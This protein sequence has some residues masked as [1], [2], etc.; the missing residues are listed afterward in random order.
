VLVIKE[1]LGKREAPPMVTP[2][3]TKKVKVTMGNIYENP[4]QVN[5]LESKQMEKGLVT[6][7]VPQQ[8]SAKI[9][10]SK[11]TDSENK[12][13]QQ[14]KESYSANVSNVN[15]KIPNMHSMMPQMM[16][17]MPGYGKV[18]SEFSLLKKIRYEYRKWILK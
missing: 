14:S 10:E 9:S 17:P 2:H 11:V 15:S 12:D 3:D 6:T 5:H 1:I 7:E 8:E 18:Y 16:Y 13:N 4:E